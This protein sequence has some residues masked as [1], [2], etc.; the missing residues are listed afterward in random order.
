LFPTVA[1]IVTM[2]FPTPIVVAMAFK[3]TPSEFFYDAERQNAPESGRSAEF[4]I[5]M[6]VAMPLF[7]GF[8]G[9]VLGIATL[10]ALFLRRAAQ[11]VWWKALAGGAGFVLFLGIVSDR[12]TLRYPT[13][14]LRNF[15]ALPW[16]LR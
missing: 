4:Y 16:P 12:L 1:L 9:F 6:P 2:V 7:A 10:I 11:L 14:L 8:V 3:K 15:V 5:G 13:G